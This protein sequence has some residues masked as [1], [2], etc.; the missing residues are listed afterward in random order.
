LKK[1]NAKLKSGQHKAVID[2]LSQQLAQLSAKVARRDQ[3]IAEA[4]DEAIEN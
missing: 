3:K 2:S 1:V 4:R